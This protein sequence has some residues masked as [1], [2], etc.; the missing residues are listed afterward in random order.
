M[1]ERLRRYMWWKG[2]L[3]EHER[4]GRAMAF[5]DPRLMRQDGLDGLH[6]KTDSQLSEGL[7]RKDRTK[8]ER[9]ARRRNRGG[10]TSMSVVSTS[11]RGSSETEGRVLMLGEEVVVQEARDIAEL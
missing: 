6:T 1:E 2:K 3:S 7:V 5:W 8:A 4:A 9:G 10:G 11:H